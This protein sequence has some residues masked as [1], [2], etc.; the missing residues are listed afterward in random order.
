M[1]RAPT[2]AVAA[3]FLVTFPQFTVPCLAGDR[4]NIIVVGEDADKT[5]LPRHNK[6]VKA[7]LEQLGQALHNAGFAVYDETALTVGKF[8]QGRSRRTD[9]EVLDIAR[10]VQ[11]PPMDVAAVFTVYARSER[12]IY[13]TKIT[14]KIIGRLIDVRSGRRLGGD[15]VESAEALRAPSDCDQECFLEVVGRDARRLSRDLGQL[16]A[17]QLGSNLGYTTAQLG[18]A[19]QSSGGFSTSFNLTFDGFTPAEVSEIEEYLVVFSGYQHLRPVR[20]SRQVHS[21]WYET[22]S[23]KSRLNRNLSKM[24]VHMEIDGTVLF[25]GNSFTV[26]KRADERTPVRSWDGW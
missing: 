14:G 5:S 9:A 7:V 10:A 21:Y 19:S 23:P 17:N 11:A 3:L 20:S 18:K 12:L 16:L 24:L 25:A 22:S 6:V 15:E 13:T 8:E 4:P 2:L 1:Q 26:E